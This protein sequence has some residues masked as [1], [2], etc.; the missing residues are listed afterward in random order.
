MKALTFESTGDAVCTWAP[1]TGLTAVTP[2][3]RAIAATSA[4][5]LSIVA[6]LSNGSVPFG[7][8]RS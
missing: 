6:S 8:T 4:V 3:K 1:S 2:C 7:A 5:A